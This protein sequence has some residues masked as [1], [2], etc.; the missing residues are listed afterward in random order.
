[1][2][3]LRLIAKLF[4]IISSC[5]L[6]TAAAYITFFWGIDTTVSIKVLWQI[7]GSSALCSL[8]GLFYASGKKEPSKKSMLIRNILSFLYVN[9]VVLTCAFAFE[10]IR[11]REPLMITVMEISII[12]VFATVYLT[13]YFSDRRE[14]ERMNRILSRNDKKKNG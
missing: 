6:L 12:A 1:M 5:V 10:W 2:D 9:T 14:A 3:T 11:N 7:L 8:C 4:V 13:N